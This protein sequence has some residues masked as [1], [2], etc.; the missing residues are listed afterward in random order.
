[1]SQTP[2]AAWSERL[3][4]AAARTLGA[5][6]PPTDPARFADEMGHRRAVD[7]SFL[8]WR[9][10]CE[11]QVVGPMNSR[12]G[13]PTDL[14][15][16]RAVLDR[17]VDVEPRTAGGGRAPVTPTESFA[18]IEVWTETELCA[19]HALWRVGDVR[20]RHDLIERCLG[21]ADWHIEHLQPD[22]ATNHPWAIHVFIIAAQRSGSFEHE[23]HAQA[24]LHNCQL[25][26]GRPDALSAH[27]LMDAA[28]CLERETGA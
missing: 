17:S 10:A 11:G 5:P 13:E 25:A 28:E 3:R 19:L 2:S 21:A 26:L 8:A 9:A 4:H 6:A 22:N 15:L 16:W 20:R 12:A 7:G 27:I 24:M 23:L 18:T 14:R 1:M